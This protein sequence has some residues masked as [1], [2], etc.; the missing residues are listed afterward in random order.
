MIKSCKGCRYR[1]HLGI[2][3]KGCCYLLETGRS[4]LGQ[5]TPEQ[6]KAGECPVRMEGI[7]PVRIVR[8]KVHAYA[9]DKRTVTKRRMTYDPD[10]MLTLYDQGKT[11]GE[12][13]ESVGCAKDTVMKWRRRKGLTPNVNKPKTPINYELVR[14]LYMAGLTDIEIAG[15]LGCCRSAIQKW[16]AE[17]LLP[18]NRPR[19]KETDCRGPSGPS[20]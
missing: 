5:M 3:G 16:R 1:S 15:A 12:I 20:Q 7:L 11:D 17:N 4:R 8:P 13:A 9:I 18:V 2:L 6:R 10:Q 14:R 19:G